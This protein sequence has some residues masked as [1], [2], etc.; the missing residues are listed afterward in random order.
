MMR[1]LVSIV[2]VSAALTLTPSAWAAEQNPQ[3]EVGSGKPSHDVST[4]IA[5]AMFNV[6]YA[7]VRLAITSTMGGIGGLIGWLNGGDSESAAAIWDNTDG[8]AFITPA[9]LEHRGRLRFG[10]Y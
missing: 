8:Q 2:F 4:A 10:R 3:R 1:K 9:I 7:P 6:G 5:A